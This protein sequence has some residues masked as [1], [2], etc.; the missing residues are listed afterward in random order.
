MSTTNSTLDVVSSAW[1]VGVEIK[2]N[3]RATAA[4][5]ANAAW[6]TVLGA[7]GLARETV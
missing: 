7:S 1:A 6:P 5:A 3:V 4:S 2:P